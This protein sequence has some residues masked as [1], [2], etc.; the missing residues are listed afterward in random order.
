MSIDMYLGKS[1]NQSSDVSSTVNDITSDSED[2]VK[3]INKFVGE[4]ELQSQAYDSGKQFFSSVLIPLAVS[5]KTLGELTQQACDEFVDK[6]QS[7][8]DTQS[9]K[10]SEL[11][12]DIKNL[13]HQISH[14]DAMKGPSTH[15]NA[16]KEMVG[17][18]K[19]Q[20]QKLKEKLDKLREFNSDSPNIFKEVE[21][22]QKNVE[23][24]IKQ[25][26]SSWNPG[27]QAFDIPSGKKMK[28]AEAVHQKTVQV[29]IRNILQKVQD[30]KKLNKKDM[31]TI[32]SYGQ[33]K[34]SHLTPKKVQKEIDEDINIMANVLSVNGS[35]ELMKD[36]G[37]IL[38]KSNGITV[39]GKSYNNIGKGMISV[40]KI[41][42]IL[43]FGIGMYTDLHDSHKTIGEA[44]AHNL[45]VSLISTAGGIIGSAVGS[46]GGP[47]TAV[48]G[49]A[50]G[51]A[52]GSVEGE[53]AYQRDDYN[54]KTGADWVGQNIFDPTIDKTKDISKDYWKGRKATLALEGNLLV[55]GFNIVKDIE[56]KI[57]R[58]QVDLYRKANEKIGESL[59]NFQSTVNPMSGF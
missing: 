53:K 5:I 48:V 46:L 58:K 7:D 14:L 20:K 15:T 24:G 38:S 47:E 4:D 37:N 10:E 56:E 18:L 41:I 33:E 11:Q 19:D 28:W 3:E 51:E 52:F 50:A 16:H 13:D 59:K 34:L 49:G 25:A 36:F 43:G 6:Y 40:G 9:L 42:P 57:A 45:E 1:R 54:L 17:S 21:S 39:D 12:E 23:E 26:K 35:S 31:Y 55:G 8:V 22:F 27:K 30:G 32:I 44:L 29:D 2:V